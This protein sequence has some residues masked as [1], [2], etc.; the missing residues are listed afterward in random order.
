MLLIATKTA[1]RKQFSRRRNNDEG[2]FGNTYT[3][4]VI[5][6]YFIFF[7]TSVM[8]QT[9]DAVV[10]RTLNNTRYADQYSS[11]QAAIDDTPEGGTLRIPVGTYVLSGS[12]AQLLLIQKS[13]TVEGDGWGSVLQ[14]PSSVSNVTDVIRVNKNSGQTFGLIFRNFAILPVSGAPARYGINFDAQ[15]GTSIIADFQLDHL[16]IGQLGGAAVAAR[17][18]GPPV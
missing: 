18:P 8:S 12:G 2:N 10:V 16:L 14:V 9:L 11:V 7:T 15:N 6:L 5:I 3:P 1:G 13:M 4:V 17:G